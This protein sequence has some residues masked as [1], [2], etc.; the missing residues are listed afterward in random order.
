MNAGHNKFKGKDT[1]TTYTTN[2][3]FQVNLNVYWRNKLYTEKQR[4]AL[5]LAKLDKGVQYIGGEKIDA[6]DSITREKLLKYYQKVNRRLGYG[7]PDNWEAKKYEEDRRELYQEK[8]I[9]ARTIKKIL[10]LW[11]Q[12]QEKNSSQPLTTLTKTE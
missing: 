9:R 10:E 5:W 12:S 3:G 1:K 2:Q 7:S 6:K 4:E 8:R 11:S